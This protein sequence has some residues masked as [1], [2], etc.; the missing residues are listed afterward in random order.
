MLFCQMVPRG[1]E[2]LLAVSF[3]AKDCFGVFLDCAERALRCQ[4][5]PGSMPD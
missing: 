2:G 3:C 5:V 4:N 1:V